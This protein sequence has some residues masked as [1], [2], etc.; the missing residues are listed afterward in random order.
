[1]KSIFSTFLIFSFSSFVYAD[2][3]VDVSQPHEEAT[4]GVVT[5]QKPSKM[6]PNP[7]DKAFQTEPES[8]GLGAIKEIKKTPGHDELT[9]VLKN[10]KGKKSS[11]SK[12]KME[13]KGSDKIQTDMN[14]K[15]EGSE[16]K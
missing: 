6:K 11:N 14:Q 13:L 7:K 8:T 2:P 16:N 5:P 3:A 12:G 1:M 4:P 9:N 10:A 15:D